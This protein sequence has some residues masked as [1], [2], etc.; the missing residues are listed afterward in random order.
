MRL[1]SHNGRTNSQG[2]AYSTKHNDRNYDIEKADN[3][4]PTMTSK[5]YYWHCYPNY[6]DWT[7]DQTELHFYDKWFTKSLESQN[8]KHVKSRHYERVKTM[9]QYRKSPKTCPEE[10][11][12]QVGTMDDHI[13]GKLLNKVCL[14]FII[15]HQK[16]YPQCKILNYAV[17]MDESTPHVHFRRVWVAKGK[18]GLWT[19]NQ[20]KSLEQMGVQRPHPEKTEHIYNNAKMT[21]TKDC[22]DKLTSICQEHGI[23]LETEPREKSKSGRTLETYK[24]EQEEARLCETIQLIEQQKDELQRLRDEY[25][26][27][28]ADLEKAEKTL[29]DAEYT[30]RLEDFC[31]EQPYV[32]PETGV[33]VGGFSALVA[34]NL[35][36]RDRERELF[37]T[38]QQRRAQTHQ[39]H[40]T[41]KKPGGD[42]ERW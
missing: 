19:V 34:F 7:F 9:D 1:V 37:Q 16:A 17:H 23:T 10:T 26:K 12:V 35:K 42:G 6:P 41:N 38:Q 13:T 32:N 27:I 18:D 15:W 39:T 3:I 25:D 21:Y 24:Y 40:G 2:K 11:I 29:F 4:M 5:N 22:R 30:S 31:A 20:A 36:E 14:E 33:P 28:T 8:A